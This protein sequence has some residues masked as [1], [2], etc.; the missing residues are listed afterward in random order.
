MTSFSEKFLKCDMHLAGAHPRT[1]VTAS[2]L[3]TLRE[4]A[5]R[6][7][8]AWDAM[9]TAALQTAKTTLAG[10]LPPLDPNTTAEG[11]ALQ[12]AFV[13][14]LWPDAGLVEAA[15][16]HI[17]RA[18]ACDN[19]VWHGHRPLRMDLYSSAATAHIAIA[20]DLLYDSLSE[21]QRGW[22]VR[23][24]LARDLSWF[25]EIAAAKSEWWTKCRMNWQSVMMGNLGIAIM[26]TMERV[27]EWQR[28]IAMAIE[29]V[30]EVLDEEGPDGSHREGLG[31]WHY[32][33]GEAAW[34]GLALKTFTGGQVNLFEHPYLRA[35]RDFPLH[36]NTP[37]GGCFDF[38]DCGSHAQGDWLVALLAREYRDSALQ[39][40]VR[41]P[42]V[43][44][45]RFAVCYDP[46][47]DASLP[48]E[49]PTAH[50]FPCTQTVCLRSGWNVDATFV[51][52]HAG[53]TTVPHAHL[54]VGSFIVGSHGRRLVPDSGVWTYDHY[55]GF[56]DV[57][58]PRWDFDGN[59]TLGHSLLLVDGQG[60]RYGEEHYAAIQSVELG[61][62]ADRIVC[63]VQPAYGTLLSRFIRYF[64]YLRPNIVVVLDDIA[65][66]VPRHFAWLLQY[67]GT[68]E[69]GKGRW[70]IRNGDA[71]ADVIFWGAK[72]EDGYR[73]TEERRT[74][75]YR[76]AY[77]T[78]ITRVV[79]FVSVGP[80][81]R[82]REWRPAAVIV[83]GDATMHDCE[84]E[85]T[86]AGPVVTVAVTAAE[87]TRT[88][89]F[90]LVN[91]SI[92]A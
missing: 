75:H 48:D 62:G 74:S 64:V 11:A 89:S 20:Y 58:G 28:G 52:F 34:F 7:G 85:F 37:D 57:S 84:A 5:A 22:I 4:R 87:E 35:T 44:D 19:W 40:L 51:A 36:M 66:A 72:Q 60:Q 12:L 49:T 41:V 15:L 70:R 30:V 55:H 42:E 50:Y 1:F 43:M 61:K 38:E 88:L 45:M 10:P 79:Q 2:M 23:G 68:V 71:A 77:S 25:F 54:D 82:Q 56:F 33:I 69:L 21:E 53:K 32:G 59:A 47:L 46:S 78:D 3:K 27:P 18:F 76:S 86:S 13:H 63:D 81:H 73:M 83:V 90:D 29:G 26:C 17:A 14:A 9:R 8:G 80:M 6:E 16:A 31:Y 91:K 65:S 39:S 92:R 24:L 67:A